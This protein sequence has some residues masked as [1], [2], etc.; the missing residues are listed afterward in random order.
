[1][2]GSSAPKICLRHGGQCESTWWQ[3]AS[4]HSFLFVS[5]PCFML[6]IACFISL[7]LW[8]SNQIPHNFPLIRIDLYQ[9]NP[10]PAS[11][12][13]TSQA[14]GQSAWTSLPATARLAS[15]F[16]K[17]L[18]NRKQ[19]K[20][21]LVPW[22]RMVCGWRFMIGVGRVAGASIE[23]TGNNSIIIISSSKDKNTSN[24]TTTNNTT[25]STHSGN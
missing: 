18:L 23:Q 19:A 8:K 6:S 14:P 4:L 9:L 20:S 22:V 2:F 16:S 13:M 21:T 10:L 11:H 25:T 17:G 1:M 15:F 24:T 12:S 7:I 5:R 3:V